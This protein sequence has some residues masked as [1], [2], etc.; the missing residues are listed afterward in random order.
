MVMVIWKWVWLTCFGENFNATHIR[1]ITVVGSY[2]T[3]H[4]SRTDSKYTS[5]MERIY[6][7]CQ[8][9]NA[10]LR[11]TYYNVLGHRLRSC[12]NRKSTI[13]QKDPANMRRDDH[14]RQEHTT[15]FSCAA[16]ECP[17]CF[18]KIG[19]KWPIKECNLCGPTPKPFGPDDVTDKI[20][21]TCFRNTDARCET[22]TKTSTTKWVT[23]SSPN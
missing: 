17:G 20:H 12:V 11:N 1:G 6:Y 22:K 16:D 18:V 13:N 8:D 7:H 19:P 9:C 2:K 3:T 15:D 21:S 23:L 5:T 14:H 4:S 10:R